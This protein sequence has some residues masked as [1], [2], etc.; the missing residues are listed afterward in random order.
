MTQPNANLH[1]DVPSTISSPKATAEQVAAGK[2]LV[3][4]EK[5]GTGRTPFASYVDYARAGM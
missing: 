5:Q 3:V 2:S 1:S 4:A